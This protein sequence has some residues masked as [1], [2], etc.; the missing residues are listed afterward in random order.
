MLV[1]AIPDLENG[2]GEGEAESD[3]AVETGNSADVDSGIVTA[4]Q[5][6]PVAVGAEPTTE[7]MFATTA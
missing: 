1:D 3:R 6:T 7:P 5:A 4:L 2:V